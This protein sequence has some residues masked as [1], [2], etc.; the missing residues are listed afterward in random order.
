MAHALI[1]ALSELIEEQSSEVVFAEGHGPTAAAVK[2]QLDKLPSRLPVDEIRNIPILIDTWN[3]N[4]S[5]LS[6][7][8]PGGTIHFQLGPGYVTSLAEAMEAAEGH[9][10]LVELNGRGASIPVVGRVSHE[11]GGNG[12]I[13]GEQ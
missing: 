10:L 13:C 8:V 2:E 6:V 4:H 12:I 3:A 9:S 5:H 1:Q 7:A 11:N